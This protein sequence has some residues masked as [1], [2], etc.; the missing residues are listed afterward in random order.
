MEPHRTASGIAFALLLAAATASARASEAATDTTEPKGN[1]GLLEALDP[2][3]EPLGSC[4]LR[5]T[6]V[7]VQI[8]G[9]VAQVTVT[10]EFYNPFE[11]KIEAIY[12]FPLHQDSAVHRMTMKVG[13]RVIRGIIKPREEAREIYERARAAGHVA[14][15]LDQERP[16]IFTQ[17][18]ANI[19]PGIQVTITIT[20]AQTLAWADG[21]FEFDFPM[22]VGPRYVPGGGSPPGPLSRATPT[23]QVPDADRISPPVVPEGMRS[24]HD[25]SLAVSINAG[26]R[27]E[28]LRSEQHEIVIEQEAGE[29]NARLRLEDRQTIPN[30]DFVLS[31]RT[32]GDRITDAVLAHT[33]ERGNFFT[34]ILQPPQRIVPEQIVPRELMF[35]IDKSGSMRGMPIETAKDAMR[36]CIESLG[37]DDTFNL[38]TFAGG[39]GS[40]FDGPV[41]NTD[42]NRRT[43]L[44]YLKDLEGGGGTEMMAAI[45]G[46]LAEQHDPERLRV[47]CFM[48]DGYVGNDMAI[49]DAVREH[50]GTARVFAFGIGSSVNRWLLDGMAEAGRG[51]VHYILGEP[52]AEGAAERF[53]E[54]VRAPVLTDIEV[55]FGGLG[56]EQVFPAAIPDLFASKPVVLKG[57]YA[58]PGRGTITLRGQTGGGP[59][60]RRIEVVLPEQQVENE[61]LAPIWARAKV[62]HLMNQDL[63]AMQRGDGD[64][65]I[66]GAITDLGLSY[67]LVT[68]FTSFVAVEQ[69]RVTVGGVPRIVD[70]PVEMPEGVSYEGVFGE[71]PGRV[72]GR[73]SFFGTGGSEAKSRA[74]PK[75]AAALP[76]RFQ[77]AGERA[78]AG[79]DDRAEPGDRAE[80]RL[81]AALR[82]FLEKW[83][84]L[85]QA[86]A[87]G[88]FESITITDG[89]VQ[90]LV[91]CRG[92]IGDEQLQELRKLGFK[93]ERTLS[94]A[95]A[96]IGTIEPE[97][98]KELAVLDF[99]RSVRAVSEL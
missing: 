6:D 65:E 62:A 77:R 1:G 57:R 35:V 17:A 96:V 21:R 53:A 19:E 50:A 20:Y 58:R 44:A 56:V 70:V 14:S 46:A 15:L 54:R 2:E 31:Y 36:M 37:P 55:D 49:I 92:T 69:A 79:P 38:L 84:A 10:Q 25:I 16:N 5:H 71:R 85:E 12:T 61:V 32:A 80:T 42:E 90:V 76:A 41:P 51:E 97:R 74:R 88:K 95:S 3:G 45:R 9:F 33:D 68:Q 40:C 89:R 13:E 91:T 86:P 93:P 66:R 23:S 4:P 83:S 60:E 67:E 8:A 63:A 52:Q 78:L 28:D 48:T 39:L 75:A 26:R 64:D 22:V 81:S 11:H 43:A 47:V 7:D 99:V 18:V 24:G 82:R 98:L 87:E 30:R 72:A 29:P 59:F 34:L 94:V 27:I 73:V